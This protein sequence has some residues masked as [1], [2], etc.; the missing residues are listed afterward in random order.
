MTATSLVRPHRKKLSAGVTATSLLQARCLSQQIDDER[1]SGFQGGD[2]NSKTTAA[3]DIHA[4]YDGSGSSAPLPCR[5][6]ARFNDP[7]HP[8]RSR[9]SLLVKLVTNWSP[10]AAE[11]N[12]WPLSLP[13]AQMPSG[14]VARSSI[15]SAWLP[16]QGLHLRFFRPLVVK[17]STCSYF[18]DSADLL[19]GRGRVTDMGERKKRVTTHK[20]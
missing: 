20:T 1:Q 8:L 6:E 16:W 9:P 10:L 11:Q 14:W 5:Q 7:P 15:R 17:S 18:L 19:A 3:N 4:V 2:L 13:G 12:G